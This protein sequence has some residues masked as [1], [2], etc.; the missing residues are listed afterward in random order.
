MTKA[1]VSS[2]YQVVIPKNIREKVGIKKGDTVRIAP[3]KEG[4]YITNQPQSWAE[5]G[6]GLGK[7]IW[8]EVDALEY[9]KTQRAGWKDREKAIKKAWGKKK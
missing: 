2:K 7:K 6:K 5:Y 3:V 4:V 9:I 8:Q 1:K